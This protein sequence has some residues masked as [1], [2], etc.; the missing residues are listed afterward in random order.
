MNFPLVVCLVYTLK[1][2]LE[3]YGF[4][5]H[6]YEDAKTDVQTAEKF[7]LLYRFEASLAETGGHTNIKELKGIV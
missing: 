5:Q 6:E 1:S 4:F 2:S 7:T 3:D